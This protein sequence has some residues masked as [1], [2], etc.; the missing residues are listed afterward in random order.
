MR[1]KRGRRFLHAERART[2]HHAVRRH[3]DILVALDLIAGANEMQR[4]G[5]LAAAL[6]TDQEILRRSRRSEAAWISGA[7]GKSPSEM[8]VSSA[9]N[10]SLTP[11]GVICSRMTSPSCTIR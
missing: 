2:S 9:C 6:G 10:V 1:H 11:C 3:E 5:R 4:E 8:I 7:S